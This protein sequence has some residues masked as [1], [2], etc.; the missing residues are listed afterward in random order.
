MSGAAPDFG[1]LYRVS[2]LDARRG[3]VVL[4]STGG[5]IT[6][7][8]R[9]FCDGLAEQ[10]YEVAAID[11]ADPAS[12]ARQLAGPMFLLSLGE[13]GATAWSAVCAE[14][15]PFAAASL[16]DP[17]LSALEGGEPRRPTAV[18]LSADRGAWP[19]HLHELSERREDVRAF[20]YRA[21]PGFGLGDGD[22]ARLARLRTLQLFH[23]SG[24]AKGEMGG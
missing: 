21:A 3:G 8:V 16:Y 19:A 24:G 15:S 14:S 18:H 17:P 6:S 1:I 12:A 11:D 7:L 13:A 9:R 20:P 4:M 2:T 23:R 10:G 22:A 5:A